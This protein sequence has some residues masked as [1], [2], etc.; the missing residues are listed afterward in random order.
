M[1]KTAIILLVVGCL[2]LSACTGTSVLTEEGA[3]LCKGDMFFGDYSD[4]KEFFSSAK[5]LHKKFVTWDQ[6]SVLG[7]VNTFTLVSVDPENYQYRYNIKIS[8][9]GKSLT[10]YIFHTPEA[11]YTYKDGELNQPVLQIAENTENLSR[12]PSQDFSFLI[13]RDIFIY[14]Y[15]PDGTLMGILWEM[16]GILFELYDNSH[17]WK[18]DRD[19]WKTGVINSIMSGLLSVD[20]AEANAAFEEIKQA[21]NSK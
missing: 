5:G 4:Y 1:K 18:D 14:S 9:L 20:E 7:E 12:Q 3:N 11:T 6:V 19:E 16:N 10:L 2:L 13:K 8:S 17:K 21:L 15:I